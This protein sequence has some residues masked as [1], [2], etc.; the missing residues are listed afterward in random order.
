MSEIADR[1]RRLCSAFVDKV[2]QVS[3][4]R[5]E[6]DPMAALREAFAQVQHDLEDPERAGTVFVGY[7]GPMTFEDETVDVATDAG[8]QT[9]WLALIGHHV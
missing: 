1:Y 8:G 9:S 5:V 6:D 3:P 7:F 2:S 4:D